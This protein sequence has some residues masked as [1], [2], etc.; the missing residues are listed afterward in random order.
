MVLLKPHVF[1]TF[2]ECACSPFKNNSQFLCDNMY[3]LVS[4]IHHF[5]MKGLHN[6][7]LC[8]LFYK[9]FHMFLLNTNDI[10]KELTTRRTRMVP[11]SHNEAIAGRDYLAA[12][13]ASVSQP[14]HL[15]WF[16]AIH[17]STWP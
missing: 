14:F 3:W 15:S 10:V 9:L 5:L 7:Q 1:S 17:S 4:F 11:P 13:R 16:L 12:F 2:F 8:N 6:S